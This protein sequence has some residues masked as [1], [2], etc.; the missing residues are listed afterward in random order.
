MNSP[1]LEFYKN[2]GTTAYDKTKQYTNIL[3]NS[4]TY[5]WSIFKPIDEVETFDGKIEIGMY[6][7]I[8]STFFPLKG[9]G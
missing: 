1:F 9:N 4:D 7:A 6:F 2:K 3:M 8:T 5:G